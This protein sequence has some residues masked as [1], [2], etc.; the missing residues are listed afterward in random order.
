MLRAW[1]LLH[2]FFSFSYVGA[3]TVVEWAGRAA[4]NTEDWA[5]RAMLYDII[6]LA[7]RLAGGDGGP[8]FGQV[9]ED[10]IAERGGCYRGYADL[11]RCIR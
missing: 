4:R 3:L 5:Q 9:K 2:L 7:T 1:L 11:H 8:D 6:R 10:Q